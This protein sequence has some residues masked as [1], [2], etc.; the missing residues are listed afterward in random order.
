MTIDIILVFVIV[1]SAVV[2]FVTERVRYDG[3]AVMVLLALAVIGVI[4]MVRAIEGFAN[5]AVVTIAA[6]LVLSGGLYRTGVANLIGAQMLRF[7]GGSSLRITAVMMLIAGVLSGIMNNTAATALLLPVVVDVARRLAIRPSRL[8]IPLC[9]ASL[10]GGMTT[11]IGTGPN[12]LLSAFMERAG[13]EAFGLFSFTPVGSAALGA[14]ILY[15]V[16]VGRHLLPDRL[17]GAG[18]AA[19]GESGSVA[20]D[21]DDRYQLGATMFSFTIPDGSA[22]DGCTLVEA[23]LGQ[24]LGLNLLAVGRGGRFIR[25]PSRVFA[26]RAGDRLVVEGERQVLGQLRAWGNLSRGQKTRG[27]LRRLVEGDSGLAQVEV[28]QGSVLIGQTVRSCGF[29][30]RFGVHAVALRR[31]GEVWSTTFQAVRMKAGDMLLLLGQAE[32]LAGLADAE[33]FRSVT[34]G[35][36]EAAIRDYG[37]RRW[38]TR[39]SVPEGSALVGRTLASS[40]LR[41]AFDLTVLQ[42]RRASGTVPFPEAS[43]QL[44]AGDQLIV[45]GPP[46]AYA[47]LEALQA[48]VAEDSAP[49]PQLLESE[50]VGLAEV[51]LAPGSSVVGKTLREVLFRQSYGLDLLA[52]RRRG[53]TVRS[54]RILLD[55]ELAFGDAL[56]VYGQR[57]RI[58]LLARDS[59]FLVLAAEHR[60]TF[61]VQKAPVATAVMLG[62]IVLAS[63]NVLPVYIAA[64]AGALLM[65]FTGC[66][67]ASEVYDLVEWRV[68]VLIAG[69]LALGLAMEESGAAALVAREVLGR[70]AAAGPQ[71]LLASLFLLCGLAAQFMPSSAVA[72]LVA[73]I[74]LGTATE[75]GVSPEALMMVVAVSS[76]CCFL[77]PFG[78]PVNLLVMGVGGYKVTD[79][80]RAGLPLFLMMMLLVVFFLP[81]VWPL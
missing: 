61:R 7:S 9:F 48:L 18:G 8:L 15:M 29:R 50:D 44:K 75:T 54:N 47:V 71:I 80:T 74:A 22:L 16:F 11:L 31:N 62:V 65:V 59:R 3:V 39:L 45:E 69:M 70:T 10:L 51:T 21:I 72:V 66:V 12:I 68:V 5:P 63:L 52:I 36:I 67:R 13:L 26:L 33:E 35:D 57:E 81:V 56:L 20:T 60:E 34:L 37:L 53:R 43:E 17:S 4:P 73:P 32:R 79:Y 55:A 2:F 49:S 27:A 38:L 25:A 40:Y 30:S 41:S 78:H 19:G 77:S 14:G 28:A 46:G 58:A 23:R 6:V 64:L 24:A 1:V 76:S 42:I